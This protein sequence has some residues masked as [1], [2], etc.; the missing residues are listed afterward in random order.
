MLT[1]DRHADEMAAKC[2]RGLDLKLLLE[3][4]IRREIVGSDELR[5]IVEAR[6]ARDS[7]RLTE[8]ELTDLFDRF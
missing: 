4:A 5:E 1:D 6:E 7:Y 3:V 8:R 2:R